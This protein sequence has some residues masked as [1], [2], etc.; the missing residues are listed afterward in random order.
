MEVGS[1]SGPCHSW[2]GCARLVRLRLMRDRWAASRED[3]DLALRG[4]ALQLLQHDLHR[5]LRDNAAFFCP[6]TWVCH[7]LPLPRL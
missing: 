3:Y 2:L 6:A 4:S 5:I 1:L 7:A